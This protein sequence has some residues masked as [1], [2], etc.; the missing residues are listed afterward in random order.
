MSFNSFYSGLTADILQFQLL[1][2]EPIASNRVKSL[3]FYSAGFRYH[4]G[5][6][7][8]VGEIP[9]LEFIS[10]ASGQTKGCCSSNEKQKIETNRLQKIN[11]LTR[12]S[13]K[14]LFSSDA[15]F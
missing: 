15:E 10:N 5:Q 3:N 13:F 2:H 7:I 12:F 6:I 9:K 8:Y 1:S 11:R 4:D 14:R